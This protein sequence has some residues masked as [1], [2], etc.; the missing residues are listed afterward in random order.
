MHNFQPVG[1]MPSPTPAQLALESFV[2][3][4]FFGT[5]VQDDEEVFEKIFRRDYSPDVKEKYTFPLLA[6]LVLITN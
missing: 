5:W 1:P 6:S 2:C 3:S 4:T